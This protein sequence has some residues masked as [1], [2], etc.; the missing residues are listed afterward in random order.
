M[1]CVNI[2]SRL[3]SLQELSVLFLQLFRKSKIISK[4]FQKGRLDI[5]T[6]RITRDKKGHFFM[7]Q[8]FNS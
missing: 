8:K 5:K 4:S 2:R 7:E 6:K 3:K 1:H